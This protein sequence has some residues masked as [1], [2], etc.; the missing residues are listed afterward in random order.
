MLQQLC[1]AG[2]FEDLAGV[3]VGCFSDCVDDRY[4]KPSVES[5]IEQALGGLG[6]PVVRGLP[7]GHVKNNYAWPMGGHAII[8]GESG[9]LQLIERGVD[10]L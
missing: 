5:V 6:I 1:S 10:E 4:P 8:D 3:G 7:F 9:E 2:K